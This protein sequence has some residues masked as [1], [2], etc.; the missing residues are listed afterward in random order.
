MNKL[1]VDDHRIAVIG[2]AGRFPHADTIERFWDNLC[3]KKDC[4]DSFTEEELLSA[5]VSSELLTDPDYVKASPVLENITDFDA[6]FFN[7]SP[8]EATALDPQQRIFLEIAWEALEQAGYAGK[9][10]QSIGVYAGSGDVVSNYLLTYLKAYPEFEQKSGSFA[11]IANDKD[12]LATRLSYKLNL[13]G[14]SISVQT[15]CSTSLVA[16]H[17]A[18]QAL[19]AGECDMALTGGINIKVPQKQGYLR[20]EGGIYSSDGHVRTFDEKAD[21]TIFGSGAGIVLLKPLSKAVKDGDYVHATI[22]ATA[23]NN[24]GSDKLSYTASSFSGQVACMQEVIDVADISPETINYVEAHGT[25]TSMGDPVEVSALAHVFNR[26]SDKK[27]YC[28]LGSVK[29]NVGH[30]DAASGVIGLIKGVLILDKGLMPPSANFET[31]N[32]RL[33][34]KTSPF[35]IIKESMPLAKDPRPKRVLVNSLG[36]G[37]TNACAIL[38]SAPVIGEKKSRQPGQPLTQMDLPFYLVPIS[39]KT[40]AAVIQLRQQYAS[41]YTDNGKPSLKDIA[42]TAGVGRGDHNFR[43]TLIVK[44]H[45]DL[46]AQIAD[47]VFKV[48]HIEQGRAKLLSAFLFTGQGAQYTGMGKEL[49]DTQPVFKTA[50]DRCADKL[51]AYLDKPLLELLFLDKNKGL[52]NQ[53]AY[54]QPA[55]FALEYSLAQLWLSWG[56]K[57]D[58]VLGHSVGEYVAATVA[59]ILTLMDGL[60]LIAA[61][62]GLMQA[63]PAG[64]AM[65]AVQTD[66]AY[67]QAAIQAA[68]AGHEISIAGINHPQQTVISG[69][70]PAI[71]R[72]KVRLEQQKISSTGLRV[73]HA[74]HSHLMEPM[75]DEFQKIAETIV[76]HEAQLPLI[77]NVTGKKIE[78]QEMNAD[79]WVRHVRQP[80]NFLGSM[81]TLQEQGC[82]VFIEM[83]PNTVLTGL[84]ALCWQRG[85]QKGAEQSEHNLEPLWLGS[86][87]PKHNPWKT[88]LQSVSL[89]YLHGVPID[90]AGFYAPYQADL[91]KTNLPTYPFQRQRY[92][93]QAEEKRKSA[94]TGFGQPL[95]PL[96]GVTLP[97][98]GDEHCYIQNIDFNERG[99]LNDHKVLDYLLFPGAAYLEI[100]IEVAR[101]LMENQSFCVR[102]LSILRPLRL[103]LEDD[104]DLQTMVKPMEE[105]GYSVSC[106]SQAIVDNQETGWQLQARW[107]LV[108]KAHGP[109]DSIIDMAALQQQLQNDTGVKELYARFARQGLQFGKAFQTISAYHI[110]KTEVWALLNT[111]L[112]LEG[113]A[114]HPLLIDGG[115]QASVIGLKNENK[116][117]MLPIGIEQCIYYHDLPEEVWV[118]VLQ[119]HSDGE[120]ANADLYF[121]DSAGTL[122]LTLNGLQSRRA[123]MAQLANLLHPKIAEP[124][125]PFWQAVTPDTEH[126]SIDKIHGSLPKTWQVAGACDK[127]RTVLAEVLQLTDNCDAVIYVCAN[128]PALNLAGQVLGYLQTPPSMLILLTQGLYTQ[129][130]IESGC[131]FGLVKTALIE[132]PELNLRLIDLDDLSTLPKALEVSEPFVA[133]HKGRLFVH[134]LLTP[135]QA[136][137]LHRSDNMPW[138]LAKSANNTLSGLK[139]QPAELSDALEADEIELA[140]KATGLNFRDV[141]NAMGLYPGDPGPLGGEVAGIVSRVGRKVRNI[142]IGDSVY[143]LCP[144]G[145]RQYA[146]TKSCLL[147]KVPESISLAQAAGI[148]TVYLTA[149][150]SLIKLAGMKKDSKVLIHAGAG[151]VGM[152][153]IQL[154]QHCGAVIYATASLHKQSQL[155]AL[156]V[157]YIYDSRKTGFSKQILA[158]TKQ[159]GVDIVLNSLTS[160]GFI[161]ASLQALKPSGTFLEIAKRNIYTRAEMQEAG[162]DVDYHIIAM[163]QLTQD[164]PEY[165]GELIQLINAMLTEQVI[166]PLPVTHYPIE[167][168]R[169]AFSFM[170]QARHM[171]KIVITQTLPLGVQINDRASYLIT[172]GLG[173]LGII[174]LKT[175]AKAGA[176]TCILTSRH[177]PNDLQ[178]TKLDEIKSVFADLT[179]GIES[180]DVSDK[181]Q[182]QQL[183]EKYQPTLKGIFHL[184]GVLDDGVISNQTPER[185]ARVFAPKLLGGKHLHEISQALKIKL[186]YFVLFSSVA[187][188][189]GSA[190]QGNYAAANSYL[191]QLSHYRRAKNLAATSINWGPWAVGGMAADLADEHARRGFLSFDE[192]TG[193]EAFVQALQQ[194]QAVI[195]AARLDKEKIKVAKQAVWLKAF[196]DKSGSSKEM[197][198]KNKVISKLK[199]SDAINQVRKNLKVIIHQVT[200]YDMRT[201]EDY[202]RSFEEMGLDSLIQVELINKVQ[203]YA[204]KSVKI[205][206]QTITAYP[207]IN[208]LAQYLLD[209]QV[210]L[211]NLKIKDSPG[212]KIKPVKKKSTPI[213][214]VESVT[215]KLNTARFWLIFL[216]VATHFLSGF[217]L[218]EG[219]FYH[220]T[221]IQFL[222]MFNNT[223]SFFSMAAFSMMVGYYSKER[224]NANDYKHLFSGILVPYLVYNIIAQSLF[225]T[226]ID[227]IF[228]RPSTI[229]WFLLCLILWKLTLPLLYPVRYALWISII[230]CLFS[231]AIPHVNIFLAL[232]KFFYYYPFFLFGF[233]YK[234]LLIKK[235]KLRYSVIILA[236]SFMLLWILY[237]YSRLPVLM[238]YPYPLSNTL[239]HNVLERGIAMA[240][241]FVQALAF[242]WMIPSSY[243]IFSE[244]GTRSLYAYLWHPLFVF[245]FLI[246]GYFQE[247]HG[248]LNNI[249]MFGFSFLLAMF[250][251]SK[252]WYRLTRPILQP[253]LEFLL[254][255]ED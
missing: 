47:S 182:V 82:R 206:S 207:T 79:Y 118:R 101:Q 214:A 138:Q 201:K 154:A 110:G 76:Y 153:A 217:T 222:T 146:L 229:S 112:S 10:A 58:Y 98:A 4:I 127:E 39:A 111:K 144:G 49:Y 108:A 24:D 177:A 35:R 209:Q 18:C 130:N 142:V 240:I 119:N 13:T 169:D 215:C 63:L 28:I 62:G 197:F 148:S 128:R 241:M 158:D 2:L 95:H 176:R 75:L 244:M 219:S 248:I 30:L 236:A 211:S 64:G 198:T 161:E 175:L 3:Q 34:L 66:L 228:F 42:Y 105:G 5:G 83:G 184:A 139:L 93:V 186:D 50:L 115:L 141:L 9:N 16:V 212:K 36:I 22:L 74:F 200:G 168:A 199:E 51:A 239:L 72:L 133:C 204:P 31:P 106:Y 48:Q 157:E 171:G 181:A 21:G 143:G 102:D 145:F 78:P 40:E 242:I 53:T 225:P 173:A 32:P 14:P 237:P 159:Q 1:D 170:Q 67:V 91:Q 167:E 149:Y 131:L 85:D 234:H 57:P 243:S 6:S 77:S 164:K 26:F 129:Q 56:V 160:E 8:R 235:V 246:G 44:D 230:V 11:H 205:S 187:G 27:N 165:I 92:W 37:G 253:K 132:N 220:Q 135:T 247:V 86:L 254:R 163:D 218:W 216:I 156:G 114:A 126:D 147:A 104:T 59:G 180:A 224:L 54:T 238:S 193:S 68:D 80:V 94:V 109:E 87:R 60:K 38:E 203:Q 202:Q 179:I 69:E 19:L 196:K 137:R 23:S 12:Y 190:G 134:R 99:Y 245:L 113:H 116:D 107:L 61:R 81:Q 221:N 117:P 43:T 88:L 29:S 17:L 155:K 120:K 210:E 208:R 195:Q 172:G 189:L 73:S 103:S 185:F 232:D 89:L 20:Q 15:A 191:D 250:L 7:F 46:Q 123:T 122:L 33:K 25:G 252:L 233:S 223:F 90:W 125:I 152:A 96:L 178:Q 70:F 121:Y 52:L 249:V 124:L 162:K 97:L 231:G 71:D 166:Q 188:S 227:Q 213:S 84:G 226:N 136:G 255:K 55:L 183:I 194:S 140:V 65:L 192:K 174:V 100:A 151:G 41:Y 150:H 45:A 251:S